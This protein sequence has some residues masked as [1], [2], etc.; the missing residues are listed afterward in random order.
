VSTPPDSD[1]FNARSLGLQWQWH[2]N[3]EPTWALPSAALGVLRMFCVPLPKDFK[4][5]WDLPDLLLQK[6][7]APEFR[8]TTKLTFAPTADNDRAGL[9]VMGADYAYL[10]IAKQPDGLYLSQAI[11]RRAN[12][13]SPEK[14]TAPVNVKDATIY[15][16]VQVTS[17]AICL[18][19]YSTDGER[20]A[21]LGEAFTAVPGRWIGAKVGLFA[22]RSASAGEAGYADFDW[23][24]VE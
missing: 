5:L 2:A 8:A 13:G 24:R 6:F 18:F 17:G 22:T 14:V 10:S 4:N 3:P 9:V 19:S 12:V 15:L 16:R 7:M 21:P 1:E 11:C 20:F 23:F